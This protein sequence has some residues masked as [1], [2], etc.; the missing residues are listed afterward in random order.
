MRTR[1]EQAPL[2]ACKAEQC[3][4]RIAAKNA[5]PAERRR[6]APLGVVCMR[7]W[8]ALLCLLLSGMTMAGDQKISSLAA[9]HEQRLEQQ[10]QVVT[11]YLSPDDLKTKYPTAGG[12][13]GTLRALLAANVFTAAQTY[14][15]Q[16]LGVVFGDVFVTDMGFHWVMVE[17]QHGKDPAI[18]YKETSILLFP[19]T[20]ISKRVEKGEEVDVFELY[21]GIAHEVEELINEGA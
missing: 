19:L 13:L 12:K 11:K 7:R 2:G 1:A 3:V 15:L 9:G 14:E 21:N 4:Q 10:R 6:Y 18:R 17:D 8:S 16:S 20:V 5:A